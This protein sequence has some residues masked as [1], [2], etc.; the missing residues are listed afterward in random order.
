MECLFQNTR[1]GSIYLI[2]TASLRK[3]NPTAKESGKKGILLPAKNAAEAAMVEGID[4]IPISHLSDAVKFL[5][6][7]SSI[8]PAKKEISSDLFS[9]KTPMID[10]S[11]IRGQAHAKRALEIA[12]SGSH[13]LLL[14]GPPGSGKTML[15]KALC[16]I[17]P[18]LSTEE[19]LDCTRIHSI[20][21]LLKDGQNLITSRPFRAPHHTVSYA[22]LIGGG[23]NPRPGEVSLAHNGILFLDELPEFS[24]STLEVLRQPLQDK[25]V[26]ISRANGNFTFPTRFVCIAAMNPCP[27]GYLGHP[28]KEC[29]DNEAQILRYKSKI[30]GPL[31]DR[32]D[33]H[34]EVPAL[35]YK[36]LMK[37]ENAESSFEVRERVKAARQRQHKR[38]GE[39]IT[40]AQMSSRQ[41]KA[42]FPLNSS[43]QLLMQ[44]AVDRRGMSVRA[45]DSIH[46]LAAT[47]ADLEDS[48]TIAEEHLL[49][50]LSYREEQLSS[51][52]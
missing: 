33:M 27:C 46:R 3:D 40:N 39:Q 51:A 8:T 23:T 12:A 1:K 41:L 26:T 42:Y 44:D 35:R 11:E 21:G 22:G 19:A 5:E 7:T 10:F 30:S 9:S 17:M 20:V 47:I 18:E 52:L 16:G 2:L 14:F 32:L 38:F 4:V 43:C 6:Q 13:N 15:S 24:R 50:A 49:E 29:R 31:L 36:D 25:Q 37:G 48:D 34:L 45:H 28:D